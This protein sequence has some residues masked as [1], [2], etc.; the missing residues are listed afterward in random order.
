[1]RDL[2]FVYRNSADRYAVYWDE[3]RTASMEQ[4]ACLVVRL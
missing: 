4:E 3:L 2:G 1:M